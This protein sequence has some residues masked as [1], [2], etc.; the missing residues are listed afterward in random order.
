MVHNVMEIVAA[1]W[2]VYCCVLLFQSFAGERNERKRGS[3]FAGSCLLLFLELAVQWVQPEWIH[4]RALVVCL[5]ISLVMYFIFR[6][7]Y[8]MSLVLAM[9]YY[10]LRIIADW[11]SFFIVD[12]VL[13]EILIKKFDFTNANPADGFYESIQMLIGVLILWCGISILKK[14]TE[15]KSY[16]VLTRKEWRVLFISTFVTV[17][18]F[19]AMMRM[20]EKGGSKQDS[21]LLYSAVGIL[22]IDF[23]VYCMANEN[24][25]R[26]VKRREDEAFRKK[27]KSEMAMYRSISENLDAQRKR[28][29]EYKNQIAVINALTTAKKYG[30]LHAYIEKIDTTLKLN[31]EVI[32]TNHVIVN[33]ILN[34]KY[35]EA[36]EKGI[37]VILNINDLSGLNMEEEDI[38]VILSN[39]LDNAIE[40]CEKCAKKTVKLKFILEE[41]RIVLSVENRM[42]KEPVVK[43]GKYISTKVKETNEHG[44]GIRNVIETVEKYGGRYVIDDSGDRFLF[45][46]L[47]T[48]PHPLDLAPSFSKSVKKFPNL[49]EI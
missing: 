31:D 13:E 5:T 17:A 11:L 16:E 6:I 24:A 48:N 7:H 29:H 33:A 28:T 37:S 12:T 21:M 26:E 38:A 23:V 10:G 4:I 49:Q 22:L 35:R 25:D 27:V 14:I 41:E 45:S 32:D 46:V 19:L 42:A 36:A 30:E 47:I 1:G 15:G 20:A 40:A 3:F 43:N 9:L 2:K 18:A 8:L 44:F 34:T 39:L